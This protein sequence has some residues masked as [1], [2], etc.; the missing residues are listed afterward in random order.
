MSL[1]EFINL[2]IAFAGVL[3]PWLKYFNDRNDKK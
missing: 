3:L 1:A 2:L